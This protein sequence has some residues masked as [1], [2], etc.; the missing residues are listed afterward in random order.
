MNTWRISS[1]HMPYS[2]DKSTKFHKILPGSCNWCMSTSRIRSLF[3]DWARRSL[4]L[5]RISLKWARNQW[6][7][8]SSPLS[9][10]SCP[11]KCTVVSK[12]TAKSKWK[13]TLT[14]GPMPTLLLRTT[15]QWLSTLLKRNWSLHSKIWSVGLSKMIPSTKTCCKKARRYSV[16]FLCT[17]VIYKVLRISKTKER[18][19]VN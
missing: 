19:E 5:S 11:P 8:S 7:L 15:S 10:P 1:K 16:N 9:S 3:P 13:G 17:I 14:S 18:R 2:R 4:R 12:K 6:R